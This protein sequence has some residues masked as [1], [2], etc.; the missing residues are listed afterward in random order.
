MLGVSRL[1]G[2]LA[3]NCGALLRGAISRGQLY[4]DK[5]VVFGPALIDAYDFEESKVIYP[6]IGLMPGVVEAY[7]FFDQS[8]TTTISENGS[9]FVVV[10]TRSYFN[11]QELHHVH[12]P[13]SPIAEDSDGIWYLDVFNIHPTWIVND[14]PEP[15]CQGSPSRGRWIS[16]IRALA[17]ERLAQHQHNER[18]RSKYEWLARKINATIQ[19][20]PNLPVPPI[21]V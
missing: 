11:P 16:D 21:A 18:V 2:D 1:F 10:P 8:E 14:A 20:D 15:G 12:Y 19:D 7:Q 5:Q 13:W 3:S 17:F 9:P 6:R 4:D